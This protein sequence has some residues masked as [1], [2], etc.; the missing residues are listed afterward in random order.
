MK[1]APITP[2]TLANTSEAASQARRVAGLHLPTGAALA[3]S[4]EVFLAGNGLPARWVGR[5]RFV[6]LATGFGLGIDFLAS[7][8]AWRRDP[9]RCERLVFV[10]IEGHPLGRDDLARAHAGSVLPELTTRL[11][12]A[13]PLATPNLHALDFE[14][15]RVQLLLGFGDSSLL[16][17][18]LV[19]KV[20]AFFLDEVET[21]RPAQTGSA[22][23][24]RRL[25]RLA[26]PGSTV[27]TMS[28]S[29]VLRD[30]LAAAGFEVTSAPSFNGTRD[31][32]LARYAPRH[33]AAAPP[34]GLH[35]HAGTREA[36]VIG[37]GLAG[38]AAAWALAAQGWRCTVLEREPALASATSGNDAG[39][40]HGSFN[41]DD[42]PHAR[43]HRAAALHTQRLLVPWL[44]D[45]RVHGQLQGVLRLEARLGDAQARAALAAQQLPRDY[46][47]W[48]PCKAARAA[49]GLALP[50]GGWWYGGAGWLAPRDYAATLLTAS[51]AHLQCG[52][53]VA[54]VCREGGVWQALDALG[55]VVG[56]APVLVLA[57]A[58]DARW[59]VG[60]ELQALS[61]VRGQLSSLPADVP[62]LPHAQVPVAG[63]GYLLPPIEGR[64]LFGATSQRDDDECDLRAADHRQNLLQLARLS[65][66][67]D[68]DR[69][70][71]NGSDSNAA[72]RWQSLPWSGRVGW[73]A[74]TPD[75]LPLIGALC[76]LEALRDATRADHPRFVPRRRDASG[77]LYVF[78]GLGSR[79]IA[80]AALGAQVLASWVSGAP[81][82]V[83]AD[84]RDA[85]DP[86]RYALRP[87]W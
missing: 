12:A 64:L 32:T 36:L 65:G 55:R 80:W 56:S 26:V 8:D 63:D 27:A 85:L 50:S 73:R 81:C 6:I 67:G 86:A 83:E 48:L 79:G 82:P 52:V 29:R 44:A 24:A 68:G 28:S 87:P 16:L 77:G 49:T 22:A 72:N 74:V 5:E 13:W 61:A 60:G 9:R 46:V 30:G 1:T 54:R 2:G 10:A 38:C 76:N 53:A 40:F 42:G 34:G 25:G 43:L 20:D 35:V 37:A 21:A 31:I 4:R 70:N 84:L 58:L 66:S 15:G 71:G 7:W 19:A 33:H 14:G 69:G 51:G 41:A 45:G 11:V 62:G 57:N 17:R 39:I 47:D 23:L 78:S 3:S 75:R 18:Q 59:L